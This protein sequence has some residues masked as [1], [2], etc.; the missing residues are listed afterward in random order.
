MQ[1]EGFPSRK[2]IIASIRAI[3]K[4]I[5]FLILMA[6]PVAISSL[7]AF[8]PLIYLIYALFLAPLLMMEGKKGV[9]DSITQSFRATKGIKFSIFI[10]QV[11]LYFV[12]NL[13]ITL[14]SSLFYST[15]N[16]GT[17]GEYLV[18]AFLRASYILMTGRLIGKFYLLAIKNQDKLR[19][20]TIDVIRDSGSSDESDNNAENMED[21]EK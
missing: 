1:A 8:I 11:F 14:V 21:H 2:A 13:P 19:N 16:S 9:I 10:N 4:L 20:G 3:P 17:V 6:A 7:L 18:M 12:M 15:G 5:A